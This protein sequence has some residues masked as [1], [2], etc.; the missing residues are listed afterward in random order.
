MGAAASAIRRLHSLSSLPVADLV[1]YFGVLLLLLG[2]FFK[3]MR[4]INRRGS[5]R[6]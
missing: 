6:P 2:I 5:T 1:T 4:K 3:V